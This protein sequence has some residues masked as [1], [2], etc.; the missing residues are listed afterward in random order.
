MTIDV[1]APVVASLATTVGGA[2][3]EEPLAPGSEAWA[4]HVPASAVDAKDADTP[5]AWIPRDPR[6]QRLTG[7]CAALPGWRVEGWCAE[8]VPAGRAAE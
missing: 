1:A 8:A 4:L 6:I 7:R 5:D 3:A 2:P